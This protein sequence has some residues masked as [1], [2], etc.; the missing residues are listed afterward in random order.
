MINKK[1]GKSQDQSDEKRSLLRSMENNHNCKLKNNR[2]YMEGMPKKPVSSF[3]FFFK[4]QSK[5]IQSEP[6][7]VQGSK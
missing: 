3:F 7:E 6:Q 5:L 2:L 4:E 1:N